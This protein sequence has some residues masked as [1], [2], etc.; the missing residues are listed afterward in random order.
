MARLLLIIALLSGM[1]VVQAQVLV[2]GDDNYPPVI[3]QQGSETHGVL[4][5]LLRFVARDIRLPI[6]LEL[7][8]WKRAYSLAAQ[9]RA[10]PA[11]SACRGT[12]SARSS[13]TTPTPSTATT[14][15]WW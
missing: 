9:G 2:Y 13:S 7:Y 3:Y 4:A 8:P 11:S 5:D 6:T 15:T 1:T 14:S 12:K 10:R